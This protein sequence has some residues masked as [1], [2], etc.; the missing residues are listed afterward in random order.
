MYIHF[1]NKDVISFRNISLNEFKLKNGL[2]IK[3]NERNLTAG[4]TI[5]TITDKDLFIPRFYEHESKQYIIKYID[6][7]AFYLNKDI[8]SIV[9]PEDSELN[10]IDDGAFSESTIEKLSIPES[11][12]ELGKNWCSY[13]EKLYNVVIDSKNQHFKMVNEKLMVGKSR[14]N[15][16]FDVILFACRNIGEFVEIPNDIIRIAPYSFNR[17]KKMKMLAF[18]ESSSLKIIDDF[19]FYECS[20]LKKITAI[21]HSV[22]KIGYQSFMLS[23]NL[24]SIEFLSDDLHIGDS[25]FSMCSL[26]LLVSCPNV[27]KIKIDY[28]AFYGSKKGIILLVNPGPEFHSDGC[29]LKLAKKV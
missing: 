29:K 19:A 8:K 6:S 15:S 14:L 25:C 11:L 20:A 21:P 4:I 1:G 17:C 10:K 22:V 7:K 18:S 24:R 13:S 27:H 2:G 12:T 5:S 28:G 3:I 26:L 9:F 16:S 23:N